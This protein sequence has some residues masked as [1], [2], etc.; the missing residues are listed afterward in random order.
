[1]GVSTWKLLAAVRVACARRQKYIEM[2]CRSFA[3]RQGRKTKA[4]TRQ[5]P[6]GHGYP[7]VSAV[8]YR[9]NQGVSMSKYDQDYFFIV[10]D[11]SDDR[12]PELVATE[13]TENRQ[14]QFQRQPVGSAPLVFTNGWREENLANKVK[15]T[16]AD[17]LFDGADLMV[18]SPIRERLLAHDIPDLAIHPA[19]Y[20]DDRGVWHEDYWYLTFT[21]EFDCWDRN[22]SNYNP[23]PLVVAG[24]KNYNVRSFS[25]DVELLDRTPLEQ[26]LLF[27]M[28]G[29]IDGYVACHKSLAPI[30]RGGGK[31]GAVLKEIVRKGF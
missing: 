10:K 20:I 4:L 1:M 23:K 31:N 3:L 16:V 12:L 29:T 6:T 7:L 24:E 19:I 13:V 14:Y 8:Q 15:E 25:L 26:R 5:A 2:R 28:G 11:S 30:F 17:I 27:K 22:T 9:M 18:R 21:A